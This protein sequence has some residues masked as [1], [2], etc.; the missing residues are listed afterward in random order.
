LIPIR[1]RKIER[2]RSAVRGNEIQGENAQ[3]Q[4]LEVAIKIQ[5]LPHE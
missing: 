1:A 2:C 5:A 3:K 4:E